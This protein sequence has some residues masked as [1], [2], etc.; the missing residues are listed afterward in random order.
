MGTPRA[1]AL[2]RINFWGMAIAFFS[3]VLTHA[4][5]DIIAIIV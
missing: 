3:L 5:F 2:G 4:D 1:I